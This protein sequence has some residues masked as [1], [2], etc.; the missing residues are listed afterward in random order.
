MFN[1]CIS[2]YPRTSHQQERTNEDAD[3][4]NKIYDADETE[5]L[6]GEGLAETLE[7]AKLLRKALRS[8]GTNPRH[9]PLQ[10]HIQ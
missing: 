1:K 3:A 6:N 9:V 7:A 10:R 5:E 4:T 2:H 8:S